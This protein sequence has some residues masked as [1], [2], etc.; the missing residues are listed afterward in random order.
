MVR[1]SNQH[2]SIFNK[3]NPQ[4]F[5]SPNGLRR[6]LDYIALLIRHACQHKT[7]VA[8]YVEGVIKEFRGFEATLM[9]DIKPRKC[10]S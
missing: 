3:E 1:H 2:I 8:P 7:I 4:N 6:G 10:M 9:V 5:K